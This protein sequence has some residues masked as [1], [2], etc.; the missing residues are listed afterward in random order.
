MTFEA[1][2][3]AADDRY[4]RLEYRRAGN[5][6]L[7][8][9]A[10]SLGLWQKFGTDYP[11]ETQREILL[12]AFD[13]GVTHFDNAN[14]YGPPHRGAE[15][16]FGRVLRSDLAP[17]RDELILT[18]KAGNP[19][20]PSPYLKGGSRKSLLVSLEHSLRDLGTDY[21]DIFYHHRPDLSTP[22]EETVGGLVSAVQ[23][24]KALYVGVSN[25]PTER[26]HD[27]AELLRGAGVPLLVHQPRYSIFD[28]GPENTGLL[29]L[30]AEDGFGLVAYSPLAQGLLTDKYLDGTIPASA[31]AANSS[32]LSPDQ[33][34]D[35]YRERATAL[36]EIARQRGQS[37]AQLALQW[38]LRQPQVTTALIGASSTSQLDHNLAALDFPPLTE[39]EL[40]L[41]DQHGIHSTGQRA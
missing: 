28:R 23:Q 9:P 7:D 32:F 12:H 17:Y 29:K 30:A 40:A 21:V 14:R 33:I 13:L 20:G 34:D 10:L 3:R 11:F 1:A 8:L 22:V 41:I 35:L 6:G 15:K 4:Q 27:V 18:T 39:E 31:R 38:V 25:Y 24:G 19:I 26:A 5:S 36:N 16:V 37:L 2:Y